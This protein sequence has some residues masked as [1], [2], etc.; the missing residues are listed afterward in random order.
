MADSKECE[1]G[2]MIAGMA[3]RAKYRKLDSEG[4]IV[5]KKIAIQNSGVHPKNRGG[6]YA[7]GLRVKNLAIETMEAGFVK[8]EVD[9]GGVVVEETPYEFREQRGKN[10][11]T[12]K[13]TTKSRAKRTSS[14]KHASKSP[15][16]MSTTCCWR[17]IPLC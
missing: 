17:T 12:G 10:Y 2:A 7:S 13:H 8:D 9:S 3:L 6:V 4:K 5:R 1:Q 11:M 16:T 14:L 15:T